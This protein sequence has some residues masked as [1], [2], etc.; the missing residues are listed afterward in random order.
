MIARLAYVALLGSVLQGC[1]ESAP[2]PPLNVVHE[3]RRCS[4]DADCGETG[5]CDEDLDLCKAKSFG[6]P[7]VL[8]EVI[9]PSTDSGFG[10]L[11]YY[12]RLRELSTSLRAPALLDLQQPPKVTG[13]VVL[14]FPP[15]RE[16]RPINVKVTLTPRETHLGLAARRLSAV[17]DPDFGTSFDPVNPFS[18]TGVPLGTYDLYWEDAG[19]VV[20][21]PDECTAV[22]QVFRGIEIT[23]TRDI[24]LVQNETRPLRVVVPWQDDLQEWIVD[25]VHGATGERL[26]TE[27][28]LTDEMQEEDAN[29]DLMAVAQ[30]RLSGV[31]GDDYESAG[32]LLRLRP[33]KG[34]NRPTI[35]MDLAAL[36][37]AERGVAQVP[38]VETFSETV[39]FDAWVWR[40]GDSRHPVHGQVEFIASTL[41]D[42][43]DGIFVRYS[44]FVD[45]AE[46]GRVIAELP[47]GS[48]RA[49]V[50]PVDSK[51]SLF[52]TTVTVW[53]PAQGRPGDAQQAGRVLEVPLGAKLSGQVELFGG[54]A[55]E[56]TMVRVV[57]INR[58]GISSPLAARS[59]VPRSANALV[60][61]RGRFT[62]ESVD[63][64]SC[65][66]ELGAA[67]TFAVQPPDEAWLPWSVA[68]S[69]SVTGAVSV[70]DLAVGWPALHFGLL[71]FR[72]PS[73]NVGAFPG[74]LVKA[75]VL[76]DEQGEPVSVDAPL[77]VETDDTEGAEGCAHRA[78]QIGETR[79]GLDGAFQLVL[80]TG[81]LEL[82]L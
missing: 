66:G 40:E 23:E 37:V 42:L 75:F 28:A 50:Y 4:S 38:P 78:L 22:P 32:E 27:R 45:I 46:D 52:E 10:G 17:S 34:L 60:D 20:D 5:V 9:P 73:G 6:L 47:P 61:E 18:F 29:G 74:A 51:A 13:N 19:I 43:P 30:L 77:C 70:G 36:E 16:C 49:R 39:E 76:L 24:T 1:Q 14:S 55:A 26:S 81:L 54:V 56:N 31:S 35:L 69:I 12:A 53:G 59:F 2:A 65:S 15:D 48:Y 25:V 3:P 82:A 58:G 80:P 72:T 62:I 44:R 64:R 33:P 8:L 11:R 79:S 57:P 63:C 71:R 41:L 21:I 67:Y 68:S 7:G